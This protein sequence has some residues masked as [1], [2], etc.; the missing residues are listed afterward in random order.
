MAQSPDQLLNHGRSLHQAR[1]IHEAMG[2]Y[3][4]VLATRPDDARCRHLP[5]VALLETKDPAAAADQQRIA[6]SLDATVAEHHGELGRA[7]FA[8]GNLAGAIPAARQALALKPDYLQAMY[9]L[10]NVCSVCQR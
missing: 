5:G 1:R 2:I 3:R 8:L 7:L 9:V 10:G 6:V 4:E